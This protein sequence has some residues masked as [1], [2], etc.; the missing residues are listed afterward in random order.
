MS[1]GATE[2]PINAPKEFKTI[3][4][5]VPPKVTPSN[6]QLKKRVKLGSQ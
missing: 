1:S 2:T 6:V 3:P 5:F 4:F